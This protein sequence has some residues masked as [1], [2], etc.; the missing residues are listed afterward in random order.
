MVS[1]PLTAEILDSLRQ[2]P[3]MPDDPSL[4]MPHIPDRVMSAEQIYDLLHDWMERME[5]WGE[6]LA[7]VDVLQKR[8]AQLPPIPAPHRVIGL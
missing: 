5:E 6:L 4:V 1:D 7:D 2:A 3:E 8:L